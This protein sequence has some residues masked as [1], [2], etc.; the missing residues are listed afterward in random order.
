MPDTKH[1]GEMDI[2]KCA[3]KILR[4]ARLL[5]EEHKLKQQ[6]NYKK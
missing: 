4:H 6:K 1:Q 5:R 2:A 3:Q